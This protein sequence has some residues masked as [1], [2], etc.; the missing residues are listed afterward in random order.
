[1]KP[2][3][4]AVNGDIANTSTFNHFADN[5]PELDAIIFSAKYL[6]CDVIVRFVAD[7]ECCMMIMT[8]QENE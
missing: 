6:E 4:L 8:G 7:G 2:F 1:M 3:V 5:I